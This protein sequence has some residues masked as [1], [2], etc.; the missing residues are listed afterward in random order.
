[1]SMSMIK[2]LTASHIRRTA[3]QKLSIILYFTGALYTAPVVSEFQGVLGL[4]KI[5]RE[6]KSNN[7]IEFGLPPLGLIGLW[8]TA[9]AAIGRCSAPTDELVQL[10]IARAVASIC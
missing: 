2:F 3:A 1:M 5:R 8:A 10:R 6:R 7:I 9:R 4:V